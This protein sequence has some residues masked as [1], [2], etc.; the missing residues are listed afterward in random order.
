MANIG[1]TISKRVNAQSGEMFI[2]STSNEWLFV[3]DLNVSLSH[4]EIVEPTTLGTNVAYSGT[5]RNQISGT[6][7]YTTDAWA[8]AVAGWTALSTK[9]N[10]EYP[11]VTILIRYTDSAGG[12]NTLTFTTGCKLQSLN[13]QRGAEGGV[14]VS[15]SFTVYVDPTIS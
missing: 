13:P 9:S 12:V 14:K 2:A 15:F 3:Q 8:A 7:L 10:N 4:Q 5:P 1:G 11:I 6:I